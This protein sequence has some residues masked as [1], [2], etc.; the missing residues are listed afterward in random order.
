VQAV[1]GDLPRFRQRRFGLLAVAVDVDQ[2]RVI[3][4]ITSRE[5]L[6]VEI[7][8]LKVLGSVHWEYTRVPPARAAIP[9][10]ARKSVDS[11]LNRY[12]SANFASD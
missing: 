12:A 7:N 9:G 2:I 11:R 3:R 4:S 5:A 10:T 1:R 8:G 6:S